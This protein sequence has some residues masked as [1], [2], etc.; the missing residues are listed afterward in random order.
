MFLLF[1]LV[2]CD[3]RMNRPCQISKTDAKQTLRR[4][5]ERSLPKTTDGLRGIVDA[6][7]PLAIFVSFQTNSEELLRGTPY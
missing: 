1:F 3:R 4:L 2:G 5:A 7:F 6:A